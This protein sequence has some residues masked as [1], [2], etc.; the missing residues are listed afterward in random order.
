MEQK[1]SDS[2]Q[3]GANAPAPSEKFNRPSEWLPIE[4]AP[5]GPNIILAFRND[6][7]KWRRVIGWYVKQFEIEVDADELHSGLEEGPAGE[8]IYAKPGWYEYLDADEAP[9]NRI[10]PTHW[11]PLPSPP[12]ASMNFSNED[13]RTPGLFRKKPVVIE[14]VQLQQRFLWPDWFHD[15]VSANAIITH[16]IGKYGNGDVY[17]EIKTLEGVMRAEA[18]DWIIRGVKGEVYPCKP[19]IFSA[20]YEPADSAQ[21]NSVNS[22]REALERI[23]ALDVRASLRVPTHGAW[24]RGRDS[25]I[26]EAAAIARTALSGVT[27]PAK[28]TEFA[29]TEA[30]IKHMVDRFLNWR[31]PES[32]NPDSGI[33]FKKTFNEHTPY[34]S[35]HEPHGTNLFNI[36]EATIMVRHMLEGLPSTEVEKI[37]TETEVR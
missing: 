36:D 29:M 20:T 34:P 26:K 5:R 17:C 33:S 30:Q 28:P 31:L 6:A 23:V 16:G 4:T 12:G 18:G 24:D 25:G 32:F 14:A 19:D 2:Y 11:M 15:A 8:A 3:A 1:N 22:L 10:W 27:Q 37:S 13:E 35:K 9:C 7:G 21:G